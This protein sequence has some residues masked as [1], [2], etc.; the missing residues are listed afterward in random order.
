MKYSRSEMLEAQRVVRQQ[1]WRSGDLRWK[2]D[3]GQESWLQ[4]LDKVP[5][6]G[7]AV[8][9]IGRQRGKSFAA[10]VHALEVALSGPNKIARYTALTGKNA[11]SIVVPTL[12]QILT[13]CPAE[14]MPEISELHGSAQW[15]NGS[16]LHW[17]GTDNKQYERQRGPRC[18]LYLADEFCFYDDLLAVERAI[19]PQR[20]TTGGKAL[21]LSTPPE[22]EAHAGVERIRA[23]QSS[24]AFCHATIHDNPRLGPAG[25]EAIAKGE[26]ARLGLSL[27]SLYASSYWRREYLA[28]LV[29]ESSR[30]VV[31][32]WP[33]VSSRATQEKTRPLIY[34][35]YV[36]V[37]FGFS[38]DPSAAVFAWADGSGT[39]H[40]ESELEV[41]SQTLSRF[42]ELAKER[43]KKLWG[44]NRFDGTLWGAK[45][46]RP[47][48]PEFLH[49][50]L[51]AN[52]PQQPYLR[53]GDNAPLVL[54]ELSSV[55]GYSILPSEKDNKHLAV[56]SLNQL[57]AEGRVTISPDCPRLLTQLHTTIWN[58]T[59]TQYER[60]SKDHGDLVD[61]LVYL[62]RNI[63]FHR[64]NVAIQTDRREVM[65]SVVRPQ[66][67][68]TISTLSN[69]FSN[70]F[71]R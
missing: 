17:S 25:V 41:H 50:T 32:S 38:P 59:R 69:L 20:T 58:K 56:D 34:D 15:P 19:L 53:V 43:E 27:E 52:A 9:L 28:E 65:L 44:V 64:S 12:K 68:Q 30:A 57:L 31:P 54:S 33:D 5:A 48:V 66:E 40:V 47:L 10:L 45:D 37:D 6:Q 8:W 29:T 13:D 4:S 23:A 42:A 11:N 67:S 35:A 16:V 60:T 63:N 7:S 39:I 61:C 51:E 55:H 18:H 36:S 2:L 14:L 46:Y 21:Y 22:S 24:G 26:A 71:A 62:V 70:K 3:A 49:R 1:L